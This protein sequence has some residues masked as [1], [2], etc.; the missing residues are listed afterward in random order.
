VCPFIDKSYSRCAD[1]LSFRNV[2]RAFVFCA[3]RYRQCPVYQMLSAG[4]RKH[5]GAGR[6]YRLAAAS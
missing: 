1:Q 5:E 4:K 2:D 3:D 6:F